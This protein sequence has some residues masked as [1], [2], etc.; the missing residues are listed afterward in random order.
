MEVERTTYHDDV[1]V[2]RGGCGVCVWCVVCVWC[3]VCFV[4][5]V[6]VWCVVCGVPCVWRKARETQRSVISV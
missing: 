1:C 5:V 6:C 2:V 4:C 3:F